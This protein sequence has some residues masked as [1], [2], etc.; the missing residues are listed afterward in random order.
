VVFPAALPVG[1]SA[2]VWQPADSDAEEVLWALAM[3]QMEDPHVIN[4]SFAV[5]GCG[6]KDPESF[7]NTAGEVVARAVSIPEQ[8]VQILNISL[9]T[10]IG[11][12]RRLQVQAEAVIVDFK[13]LVAAAGDVEQ[14]QSHLTAMVQGG[15]GSSG[16]VMELLGE[17]DG[18]DASS[19]YVE[20][21][22]LT[23]SRPSAPDSAGR[24]WSGQITTQ[25]PVPSE[26]PLQSY[27]SQLEEG[28]PT[29][30]ASV[31]VLAAAP[32]AAFAAGI[33]TVLAFCLLRKKCAA[34]DR[35]RLPEV[36]A[37]TAEVHV[38]VDDDLQQ[39]PVALADLAGVDLEVVD[40]YLQ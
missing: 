39:L 17:L 29:M 30:N 37:D 31:G 20:L 14:V 6:I 16:L 11:G 5:Y 1:S 3:Q 22:P 4:G 38:E 34:R 2:S 23:V 9:V 12:A 8:L 35:R 19:V 24:A 21:Q 32:V 10:S 40:E 28:K 27:A 18:V 13:I 15:G 33:F 36:Q 25:S 26:V 7:A